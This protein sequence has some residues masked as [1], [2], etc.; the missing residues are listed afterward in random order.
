MLQNQN[1]ARYKD[2]TVNLDRMQALGIASGLLA[3]AANYLGYKTGFCRCFDG[4]EAANILGAENNISLAM[5]I[6]Y[7]NPELKHNYH[8][9]DHKQYVMPIPKA[10]IEIVTHTG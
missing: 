5:G 10:K 6:G 8:H 3:F 4:L 1:I 2:L 7:P 9:L